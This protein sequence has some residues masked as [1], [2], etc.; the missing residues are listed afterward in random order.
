MAQVTCPDC[1]AAAKKPYWGAYSAFC[2][3]CEVRAL[4]SGQDFWRSVAAREKTPGYL[5]ALATIFGPEEKAQAAGHE[6]V[7][8]EY[9]RRKRLIREKQ[10]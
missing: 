4:A 5:A 7:K 8:A 6:L 2:R 1:T 9:Q 10:T 3:G